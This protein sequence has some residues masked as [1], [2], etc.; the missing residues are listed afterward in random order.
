M[1][2]GWMKVSD[3]FALA[4]AQIVYIP[5]HHKVLV[6]GFSGGIE[7][8][9]DTICIYDCNTGSVTISS[10]SL[11]AKIDY[12][13]RVGLSFNTRINKMLCEGFIKRCSES[14]RPIH[15]DFLVDAYMK[16]HILHI[17]DYSGNVWSIDVDIVV[18]SE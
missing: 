7:K 16:L 11:P 14:I 9:A 18:A 4:K 10:V 6:I 12:V 15:V 2:T 8:S 13:N 1:N 3:A 5:S 17:M